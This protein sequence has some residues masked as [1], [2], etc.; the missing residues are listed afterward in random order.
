LCGDKVRAEFDEVDDDDDRPDVGE[1]EA[2][3]ADCCR[4]ARRH[5]DHGD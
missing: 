1:A 4:D 5:V 2:E 3:R